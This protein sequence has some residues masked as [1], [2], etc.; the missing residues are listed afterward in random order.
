[1]NKVITF[2]IVVVLIARGAMYIYDHNK[3]KI[4]NLVSPEPSSTEAVQ[5]NLNEPDSSTGTNADRSATVTFILTG[6][7]DIY[8]YT[9]A[10]KYIVERTDKDEVVKLIRKYKENTNPDELMFIIKSA[11][12]STYGNTLNLLDAMSVNEIPASH[13]DEGKTTDVEMKIINI[14]KGK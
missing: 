1:M 4:Q 14:Y 2:L 6:N 9:G 7:N 5:M 3:S 10:F 11:E 12:G 13:Y 8:Y